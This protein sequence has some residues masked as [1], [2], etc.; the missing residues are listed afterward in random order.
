[1]LKRVIITSWHFVYADHLQRCD[2]DSCTA[3]TTSGD[4]TAGTLLKYVHADICRSRQ[5][6]VWYVCVGCKVVLFG[7][8]QVLQLQL[9]YREMHAR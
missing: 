7:W 9:H 1:M 2:T 5:Q 8:L 6:Q 4:C 3:H